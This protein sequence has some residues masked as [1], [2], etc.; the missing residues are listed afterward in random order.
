MRSKNA[1]ITETQRTQ[2]N[3]FETQLFAASALILDNR[4][5]DNA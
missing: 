3:Y 2:R 5:I 1:K 4:N